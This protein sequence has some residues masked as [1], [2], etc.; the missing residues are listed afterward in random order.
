MS[1]GCT[2]NPVFA[3][4]LWYV[5]YVTLRTKVDRAKHLCYV[6]CKGCEFRKKVGYGSVLG[7]HAI[8]VLRNKHALAPRGKDCRYLC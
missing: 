4:L 5:T 3:F 1:L 6:L 7:C 2:T 8:S